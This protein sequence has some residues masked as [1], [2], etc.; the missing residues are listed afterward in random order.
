MIVIIRQ[1]IVKLSET[2]CN[3]IGTVITSGPVK[4]IWQWQF[5]ES[6]LK[7]ISKNNTTFTAI[8]GSIAIGI[9]TCFSL[10]EHHPYLEPHP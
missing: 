8:S 10:G 2:A 6:C 3:V 1:S 9:G 5:G 4:E 7:E